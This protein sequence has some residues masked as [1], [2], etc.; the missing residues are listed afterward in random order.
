MASTH[1]TNWDGRQLLVLEKGEFLQIC[2]DGST[3][4]EA[5]RALSAQLLAQPMISTESNNKVWLTAYAPYHA[6]NQTVTE[7]KD[8]HV[9]VCLTVVKD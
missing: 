3:S 6:S 5:S 2:D 9:S 1:M 8:G 4:Q 7:L